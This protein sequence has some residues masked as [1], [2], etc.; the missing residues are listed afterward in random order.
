[1]T[2][3]KATTPSLTSNGFDRALQSF[4]RAIEV[5]GNKIPHP[6]AL[7][8]CLIVVLTVAS[9]V[10]SALGV[11]VNT[12]SGE[13]LSVQNLLS[14]EGVRM[15][16]DDG[17]E[18]FMLFGPFG[19]VLVI[20]MGVSVATQT[21]YLQNLL[22]GIVQRV[23]KKMVTF[24]VSFSA[25]V[26]H[27][28]SD[29]AY[30]VMA[31]IGA[32]AFYLIGRNPV[33]G[34]VLAFVS[35]GAAY[36]AAPF[37]TPSDA[38]FAGVTTAA[39]QTVQAG[40]TVTPVS[41]IFFTAASSVVMALVFT[42]LCETVLEKRVAILGPVTEVP[43]DVKTF[44]ETSA[45]ESARKKRA[46]RWATTTL[47]GIVV[48]VLLAMIPS[49][50]PLR[51]EDGG[52]EGS[53]VMSGIALITAFAFLAAGLV[54]GKLSGSVGSVQNETGNLM[55]HGVK[56]LGPVIALFFFISQFVAYFQWTNIA[57]ILA[58]WGATLLQA[59][60]LPIP[61]LLALLVVIVAIMNVF[62]LG[63]IAMYSLTGLIL[64]PMLFSVGVI[65]EV[66]QTAVRIGD[67]I[68]NPINPLNPYFLWVLSLLKKYIPSAGIG[69]LA[70]MTVPLALGAGA[71]WIVFFVA[72]IV[73]GI[74][75]GI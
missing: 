7:F 54:Y 1:M 12:N 17:L 64:V 10:M 52:L 8:V 41:T 34:M 9:A 65:P 31:P 19:T 73:L 24:A 20:M 32:T 26:A 43:D 74:P 2:S 14:A 68:T 11:S 57:G 44:G 27:V 21:G 55:A 36:N 40:Y 13:S 61:L 62:T 16:L 6:V 47:V 66:T 51:A 15:A 71:V 72:W 49:N 75:L 25:M 37:I 53:P 48:V 39:A 70:S 50:S 69:T 58:V 56:E 28:A 33:T 29:A 67:C 38:M 18:N 30:V 45:E 22:V 5:V 4:L 3:T 46:S 59:I 42:I 60:N 35:A 63:G 23:P